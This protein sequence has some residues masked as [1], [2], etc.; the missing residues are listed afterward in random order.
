MRHVIRDLLH[1]LTT[2]YNYVLQLLIG[3]WKTIISHHKEPFYDGFICHQISHV[4]FHRIA[5]SKFIYRVSNVVKKIDFSTK[6]AHQDLT[7]DGWF[8]SNLKTTNKKWWITMTEF[9]TLFIYKTSIILLRQNHKKRS[10]DN[11]EK[12]ILHTLWN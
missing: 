8:S 5:S 11:N 6:F 12:P 3:V 7:A 9:E 1:I 4:F 10:S 2:N